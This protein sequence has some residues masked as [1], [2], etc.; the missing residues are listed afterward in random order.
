VTS[1][2]GTGRRGPGRA[3]GCLLYLLGMLAAA[4]VA[5]GVLAEMQPGNERP[6]VIRVFG[7]I[8]LLLGAAVTAGLFRAQV[9]RERRRA[10]SSDA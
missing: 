6:D 2:G 10:G 1:G 5:T 4:L 8:C 9:R 7:V 3:V